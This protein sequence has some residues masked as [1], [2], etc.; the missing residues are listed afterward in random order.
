MATYKPIRWLMD[1][2]G[3]AETEIMIA[4]TFNATLAKGEEWS[5]VELKPDG[6][7]GLVE[8]STGYKLL[9]SQGWAEEKKENGKTYCKLTQKT[10]DKLKQRG[11]LIKLN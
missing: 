3:K 8:N 11:E 5:K 1:F 6:G 4:Q 10:L 9:L 2:T 7:A